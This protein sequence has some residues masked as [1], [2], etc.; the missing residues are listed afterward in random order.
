MFFKKYNPKYIVVEI[1][2][3]DNYINYDPEKVK[4]FIKKLGYKELKTLNGP[5]YLFKDVIFEYKKE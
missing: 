5:L 1:Q 2:K 3:K 4:S